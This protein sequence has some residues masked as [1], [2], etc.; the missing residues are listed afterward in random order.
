[1]ASTKRKNLEAQLQRRV[2]ARRDSTE[3]SEGDFHDSASENVNHK[4]AG[5]PSD[6]DAEDTSEA[7]KEDV[8]VIVP[9]GRVYLIPINY[10]RTMKLNPAQNPSQNWPHPY[11]SA[12]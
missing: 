8:V 3:E 1:M 10:D 4:E 7:S 12:P 2:R 6:Q 5:S 9:H 11:R